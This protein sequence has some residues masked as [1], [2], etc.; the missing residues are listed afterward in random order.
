VYVATWGSYLAT[1]VEIAG[2]A[3]ITPEAPHNYTQ[4]GAE[5]LVAFDPEVVL[6]LVQAL[7]APVAVPG[8]NELAED[9]AQVW[10]AIDI[11]AVRNGRIYTLSDKKLV[12]PSQLAVDAA[13]EMA[14]RLHPDAALR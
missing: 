2:G 13:K 5:A 12:H 8:M 10:R 7:N 6:D 1:L 4:I 14:R 11:Q 3:P 9:P